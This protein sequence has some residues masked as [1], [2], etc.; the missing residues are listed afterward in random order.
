[1]FGVLGE[2]LGD[3]F[4]AE[5]DAFHTDINAAPGDQPLRLLLGLATKGAREQV[6]TFSNTTHQFLLPLAWATHPLHT[7]DAGS[8]SAE[9]ACLA[10]RA[11]AESSG[12]RR[13]DLLLGLPRRDAPLPHRAVGRLQRGLRLGERCLREPHE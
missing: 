9:G 7:T 1:G 6:S 5:L 3:D 12:R 13:S 2:F 4:V 11:V 8:A 10:T